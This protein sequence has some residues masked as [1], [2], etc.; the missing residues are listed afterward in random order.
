MKLTPDELK[1]LHELETGHF[2]ENDSLAPQK[3]SLEQLKKRIYQ[4]WL[5]EPLAL[6]LTHNQYLAKKS[7]IESILLEEKAYNNDIN[8]HKIKTLLTLINKLPDILDTSKCPRNW[9]FYPS[10]S[11]TFSLTYPKVICSIQ[12]LSLSGA[13]VASFPLNGA[14]HVKCFTKKHAYLELS[15]NLHIHVYIERAIARNQDYIALQF[16]HHTRENP[17]LKLLILTH[18]L[19]S[20]INS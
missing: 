16:N 10:P 5:V 15:D 12:S 6:Y 18:Y 3:L 17:M 11:I 7:C 1:L 2:D 9:R 14:E 13:C 4:L 8:A 19:N 20:H